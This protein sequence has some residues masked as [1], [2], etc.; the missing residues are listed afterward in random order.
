MASDA[1]RSLEPPPHRGRLPAPACLLLVALAPLAILCGVFAFRVY[2]QQAFLRRI[3]EL[4]GQ[5]GTSVSGAVWLHDFVTQTCGE[6]MAAVLETI[7]TINLEQ[8]EVA[9]D[10]LRPLRSTRGLK[11]LWLDDTH[12]TDACLQYV[13]RHRELQTLSLARTGVT[14][15]GLHSIGRLPGLRYL[16]LN[17]V[18]L[19]DADLASLRGL[20]DLQHLRLSDVPITDA[21]LDHLAKLEQLKT[22]LLVRTQT[23]AA[24]VAD[25]RQELP[26]CVIHGH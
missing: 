10:D 19:T 15:A 2:R 4:N 7:H 13:T 12:V 16:S 14:G 9:D 3:D 26:A 24:R 20:H 11:N 17:G 23:S 22:L 6:S 18:R 21:G 5:A 25:L 1:P 8:T